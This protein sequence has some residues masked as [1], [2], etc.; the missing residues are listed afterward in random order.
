MDPIGE[1]DDN[2]PLDF[3]EYMG[4]VADGHGEPTMDDVYNDFMGDDEGMFGFNGSDA[5]DYMD[6]DYDDN[7]SDYFVDNEDYFLW[8]EDS[9]ELP[10]RFLTN[11]SGMKK[12]G[13]TSFAFHYPSYSIPSNSI[14]GPSWE[15]M[16]NAREMMTQEMLIKNEQ[17]SYEQLYTLAVQAEKMLAAW[18]KRQEKSGIAWDVKVVEGTYIEDET[19]P[20]EYKED[21]TAPERVIYS[22]KKLMQLLGNSRQLDELTNEMSE[23]KVWLQKH[24]MESLNSCLPLSL[25]YPALSS[26]FK[27]LYNSSNSMEEDAIPHLGLMD[28]SE[29]ETL[30]QEKYMVALYLSLADVYNVMREVMFR[31]PAL[32]ASPDDFKQKFQ[33]F[34]S[35]IQPNFSLIKALYD[36]QTQEKQSTNE[37]DIPKVQRVT[38]NC[39][40][41]KTESIPPVT[42]SILSNKFIVTIQD[43]ADPS[44]GQLQ[45]KPEIRIFNTETEKLEKVF[46]VEIQPCSKKQTARGLIYRGKTSVS[47]V[48]NLILYCV[49]FT[50]EE[51]PK[52]YEVRENGYNSDETS[53]GASGGQSFNVWRCIVVDWRSGLAQEE[54]TF[55]GWNFDTFR[56][57]K[58]GTKIWITAQNEKDLSLKVFEAG[59]ERSK[60]DFDK[61]NIVN[62]KE[63]WLVIS[64]QVDCD[65]ELM[66]CV[67][68]IN[69]IA[70]EV[71]SEDVYPFLRSPR[72]WFDTSSK[73]GNEESLKFVQV[74]EESKVDIWRVDHTGRKEMELQCDFEIRN[75]RSLHYSH[76]FLLCVSLTHEMR[77][78]YWG[79]HAEKFYLYHLKEGL[80]EP[81]VIYISSIFENLLSHH[82]VQL[83]HHTVQYP[84]DLDE[85]GIDIDGGAI[86]MMGKWK[87]KIS[88]KKFGVMWSRFEFD[89]EP[90]DVIKEDLKS[91]EH[92]LNQI[93]VTN[94]S[95]EDPTKIQIHSEEE[96][97]NEQQ[98]G[99]A[100]NLKTKSME[101]LIES[102]ER[103]SGELTD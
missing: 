8:E 64:T 10:D 51:P 88:E 2:Q 97:S 80:P 56:L 77:D 11:W 46:S 38:N 101:D 1:S 21:M 67:K 69:L 50:T 23:V 95:I 37:S 102:G 33:Y 62:L 60:L 85:H 7:G 81:R 93:E 70:Y 47:T 41:V 14:I 9:A 76:P 31:H 89:K 99:G 53:K 92:I 15:R 96:V 63:N 24:M 16:K 57:S 4:P 42:D 25:P 5:D 48:E 34:R 90:C 44:D 28:L 83:S 6:E 29:A 82:T 32:T 78:D 40:S 65:Q 73:D 103:V 59:T 61:C 45:M 55:E 26:L 84:E 52:N 49:L 72:I 66:M 20:V 12:P 36:R 87:N 58:M 3:A 98:Q 79:G 86:V 27:V 43:H 54:M 71:I 13:Q 75:L 30:V 100:C 74:N 35:R 22:V 94:I 39:L 18:K 19:E 91:A 68:W 17:V